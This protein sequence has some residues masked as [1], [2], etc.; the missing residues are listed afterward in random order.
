MCERADGQSMGESGR[1]S[2]LHLHIL[3]KALVLETVEATNAVMR[4]HLCVTIA[5]LKNVLPLQQ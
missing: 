4:R 3:G 2:S 1:Q 5:F